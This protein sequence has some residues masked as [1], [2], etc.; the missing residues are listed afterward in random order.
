MKKLHP[1]HAHNLSFAIV[2]DVETKGV[3]DKAVEGVDGVIHTAS[4]FVM[5]VENNERHLLQPALQGTKNI[6]ESI[7]A[8]APQVKRVVITSS[9]A[10][11]V[12]MHKGNW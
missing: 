3:F 7:S 11:I 1:K 2:P 12:N 6:L 9:F 8:H 5:E 4:P 10:A